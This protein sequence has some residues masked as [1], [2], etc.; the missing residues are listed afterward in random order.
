MNYFREDLLDR[1]EKL[2]VEASLL[3]EGAR[4]LHCVLV[5]G[6]A[7]VLKQNIERSTHDID[8]LRVSDELISLLEKHDMNTNV[9]AYLDSFPESYWQRIRRFDELE[10]RKIDY[11]IPSL[12]DL[13][14]S[15]LVAH[16]EQDMFDATTLKVLEQIDW[17]VLETLVEE[18]QQS[19]LSDR[20]VQDFTLV[21]GAYKEKYMPCE[22]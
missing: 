22:P 21:Y 15:K 14:V 3:F 18:V 9:S 10:T 16:R 12:E 7:L 4:R 8:I 6:S 17:I 11:F 19:L 20:L 1:L 2:D 13:I 5:G